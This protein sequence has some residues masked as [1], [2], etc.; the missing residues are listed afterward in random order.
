MMNDLGILEMKNSKD[1]YEKLKYDY[2]ILLKK[3][4]SYNYFN[5]ILVAYHLSEWINCDN[6]Q[7]KDKME[8]SKLLEDNNINL[9][10]D[11]S[12]RAKHFKLK[13]YRTTITKDEVIPGMDYSKFDYSKVNYGDTI[14]LVEQ[15]GKEISLLDECKKIFNVYYTIFE[16]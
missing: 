9:F 8:Y 3:Q 11:L 12:N 10:R 7:D 2:Y 4:N 14:F 15:D 1:L 6:F 16:K 13:K 5:F